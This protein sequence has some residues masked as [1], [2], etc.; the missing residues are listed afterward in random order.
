[1]F[2]QAVQKSITG[3]RQHGVTKAQRQFPTFGRC[4]TT[5]AAGQDVR[6]STRLPPL[7]GAAFT[8]KSSRTAAG[9]FAIQK[10][11]RLAAL[12]NKKLLGVLAEKQAF[13]EAQQAKLA[14]L[15][16]QNA[17]HQAQSHSD[18]LA[19]ESNI[20]EANGTT[21][22]LCGYIVVI[23]FFILYRMMP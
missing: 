7:P 18:R 3:L 23:Y 11:Q 6:V 13:L 12:E 9:A 8:A 16:A 22:I 1:M 20:K 14:R 2:R 10:Q 21:K 4:F 19:Y 17:H 15:E 5:A